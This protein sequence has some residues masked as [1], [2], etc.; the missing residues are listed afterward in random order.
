[1]LVHGSGVGQ[2]N[3]T[4]TLVFPNYMVENIPFKSPC[5]TSY[6]M[7]SV[8]TQLAEDLASRGFA[9]LR[10]DKRNCVKQSNVPGCS[11]DLCPIDGPRTPTCVDLR[12][13]TVTDFVIDASNAV[14]FL[15]DNYPAIDKN[16]MTVIGHSQGCSVVPYVADQVS[17]VKRAIQLAGIGI[18][19]DDVFMGQLESTIVSYSTGLGI[20]KATGGNKI[21]IDFLTDGVTISSLILQE[22]ELEFPRIKSGYY[23]RTDL[24]RIGGLTSAGF[25]EDWLNW[26]KFNELFGIMDSLAKKA[27]PVLSINSPSDAQ[28]WAQFYQPLH[29]FVIP[30]PGSQV[31]IIPG[32]THILTPAALTNNKID[33][34]VIDAIT[35]FMM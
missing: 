19:I 23:N 29:A 31:K 12:T 1:V 33:S 14:K 10:Y 6:V 28:V 7:A 15:Q 16:D 32:L 8:F 34:R 18:P 13:L 27:I 26:G 9:V 21:I 3:E 20:C 30:M 11:Y 22:S 24:V 4:V 25:W 2:R 35:A 5:D 17:G